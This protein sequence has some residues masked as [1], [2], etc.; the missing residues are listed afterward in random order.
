MRDCTMNDLLLRQDRQLNSN[1]ICANEDSLKIWDTMSN[2]YIL[3][4]TF[5]YFSISGLC[6]NYYR[7]TAK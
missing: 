4:D 5:R 3:F 2:L 6:I 7:L 1:H